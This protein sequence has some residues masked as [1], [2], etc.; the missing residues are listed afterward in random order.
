MRGNRRRRAL[1]RGFEISDHADWPALIDTVRESGA[2]RVIATHGYSEAVARYLAEQ[3]LET[4]T[5]R[6][7]YEGEI[8]D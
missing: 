2:Q 1:D 7:A 4:A 5:F 8:D 6:T 3:G